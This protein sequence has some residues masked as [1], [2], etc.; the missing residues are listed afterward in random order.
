MVCDPPAQTP[1]LPE[2]GYSA[3]PTSLKISI[4]GGY[5]H[6]DGLVD[7]RQDVA[8]EAA[9]LEPVPVAHAPAGRLLL[10][11]ENEPAHVPFTAPA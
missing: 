6:G 1:T 10:V 7:A 9:V 5:A 2:S 8:C 4:P 3:I 11:T